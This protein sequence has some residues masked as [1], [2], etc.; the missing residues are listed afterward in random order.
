MF[1]I[2][3]LNFSCSVFVKFHLIM[4]LI[5]TFIITNNFEHF[6]PVLKSNLWGFFGVSVGEMFQGFIARFFFN[7]IELF[8]YFALISKSIAVLIYSG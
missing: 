2:V 6:F 4:V 8:I 1:G 7:K 3:L 5:F